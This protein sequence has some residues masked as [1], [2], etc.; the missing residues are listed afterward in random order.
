[1]VTKLS[2]LALS[3]ALCLILAKIYMVTKRMIGFNTAFRGLILAKIYM[4]TKQS[5]SSIVKV[6]RLILAKIYMVTKR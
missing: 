5:V 6:S 3:Q 4:V 1:M 2:N